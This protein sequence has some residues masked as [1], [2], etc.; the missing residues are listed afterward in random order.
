[1]QEKYLLLYDGT[2]WMI[3]EIKD[4]VQIL[5]DNLLGTLED[6]H[7]KLSKKMDEKSNIKFKQFVNEIYDG[8]NDEKKYNK[9]RKI[10]ENSV[11][12]LLYNEKH[13]VQ[14]TIKENKKI[15]TKSKTKMK[16]RSD[17]E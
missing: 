4:T 7:K 8:D 14:Q 15:E 10:I 1:M 11:K 16:L 2:K 17:S 9:K 5:V 3:H 12:L 13:I 6:V